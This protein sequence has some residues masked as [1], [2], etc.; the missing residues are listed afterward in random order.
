MQV[1]SHNQQNFKDAQS[2]SLLTN[3]LA[4]H[5]RVMPNLK[6]IDKWPNIDGTLEFHDTNNNFIGKFEAQVKTLPGNH[7]FKISCP[8]S[9]LEYCKMVPTIP[10]L[11]LGVDNIESKI[12]WLLVNDSFINDLKADIN[13][14]SKLIKFDIDKFIS[15]DNENYIQDWEKILV[16]NRDKYRDFIE[17]KEFYD[18]IKQKVNI[19]TGDSNPFF[20]K[21]HIF[22]DEINF[23]LDKKLEK[24]KEIFFKN[25]WKIGIAYYEFTDT[26]LGFS[27]YP[28]NY[29]KN[30]I[31][32][33]EVGKTSYHQLDLD[34]QTK[35]FYS[36]ENPIL[37]NPAKLILKIL[38]GYCNRLLNNK[39]LN[40]N[41]EFLALEFIFAFI[42]DF[43]IQLGLDIKNEYN[44]EEIEKSF[45]KYLPIWTEEANK[46]LLT[47][48][49]Y[50]D[51]E[52]KTIRVINSLPV[53]DPGNLIWR[54]TP[55]ERVELDKKVKKRIENSLFASPFYLVNDKFPIGIFIELVD[56]LKNVK[57]SFVLKNY[58][59]Q[60]DYDRLKELKSNWVWNVFKYEDFE[61]N[62]K[63]F[64]EKLPLVYQ[65][66][67]NK[68]FP[69]LLSELSLFGESDKIVVAISVKEDIKSHLDG[70][71][72]STFYLKSKNNIHDQKTIDVYINE[73][74]KFD[75]NLEEE[76]E[77]KGN[78]YILK[79]WQWSVLDFIYEDTPM[80][81]YIQKLLESRLNDYLKNN[82][83]L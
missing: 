31:Q 71:T 50:T 64:F 25:A 19:I 23:Y 69:N 32:I 8:F 16:I 79:H 29:N 14:S 2:I 51:N 57:K 70:P 10:V 30:D 53:L 62:I 72:Y 36:Q 5:R 82:F 59:K 40:Y 28:I 38:S 4:S 63:L 73:T 66:L 55:D 75:N 21:I 34:S 13:Q 81:N 58:Y 83:L 78:F 80:F 1:K 33:M 18:S 76:V 9:F 7:N 37:S 3:I 20:P 26:S 35:W 45:F 43:K 61:Y 60:K 15:K 17:R 42:K 11:F 68:N 46:L 54:I 74:I 6:F 39:F 22:L 27:L 44:M 65:E 48:H 52:L 12:Y 47:G 49:R 67:L 77:Y 41:V 56:Y 24:V